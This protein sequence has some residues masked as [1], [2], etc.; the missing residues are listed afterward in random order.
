MTALPLA[1]GLGAGGNARSVLDAL[2]LAG[3]VAVA[4]LLDNDPGLHGT[5]LDGVPVLG[6]DELLAR[7]SADGIGL[8]FLGVGGG[9]MLP[10]SGLARHKAFATAVAAG[11]CPLTVVHPAAVISPSA[12]VAAGV[13]VMAAA[14]INAGAVVGEGALVNTGAIIEHDCIIGAFSHIATGARLAGAVTVGPM[15]HV[16]AGAVVRQGIRIGDGAVVG[17]GAAVIRPVKAGTVVA[18]VPARPLSQESPC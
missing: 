6:G 18:G 4:G 2:R 10:A 15:A 14:V 5:V 13:C 3:G 12:S 8:F 17:I 9:G 16:G 7:L 11:L 1:I